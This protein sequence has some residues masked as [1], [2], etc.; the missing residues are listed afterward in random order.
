M[1]KS[2]VDFRKALESVEGVLPGNV[3]RTNKSTNIVESRKQLP[4]KGGMSTNDSIKAYELLANGG[5]KQVVQEQKKQVNV[6]S[7][8]DKYKMLGALQAVQEILEEGYNT[9]NVINIMRGV[10]NIIDSF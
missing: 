4:V 5:K 8:E 10:K 2:S 6:I 1:A 9:N 3:S 7:T